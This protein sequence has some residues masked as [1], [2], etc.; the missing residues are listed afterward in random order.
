MNVKI[1]VE[2]GP[3]G[4]SVSGPINDIVVALGL[5]EL[6]KIEVI[7]YHKKRASSRIMTADGVNA[8]AL[9]SNAPTVTLGRLK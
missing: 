2:L 9:R 6:G 3:T 1:T 5:L 7:E 8:D 4:V